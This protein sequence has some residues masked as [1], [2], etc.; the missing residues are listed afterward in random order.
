MST[1][2]L[3]DINLKDIVSK[4]D[5]L[6]TVKEL[7]H[8]SNYDISNLY[9]DRFWD[10][11][12][13]DKW[14]YLD[15]EL[16][17]WMEYR[18]IKIGK[19]KIIKFLNREFEEGEDYKILNNNEFELNAF[20]SAGAVK[21][22]KNEEKRG[23]HN[24]QYIVTS[25]DCFKE[26]CMHIGT[27]KSKEIKKYYITLEKIFKFYLEYQNL[28]QS[29]LLENKDKEIK[30]IK[31]KLVDLSHTVFD[32]KE[33]KKNTYLYIATNKHLSSQN[34][35]KVGVAKNLTMRR[36]GHNNT[37]NANDKFYYTYSV[38]LH[39][40]YVVEYMIKHI[41]KDFK[42][43]DSNEI[44]IIK[45]D[46]LVKIIKNIVQNYEK[47]ITYYN[48]IMKDYIEDTYDTHILPPKNTESDDSE[49]ESESELEKKEEEEIV[50]YNDNPNYSYIRYKNENNKPL[51]K[52]LRCDYTFN[53]TD[54]LQNHYNRKIKCYED[55][56]TERIE[57]IRKQNDNP[58]ILTIDENPEYTYFE[59]YNEEKEE[60]EYYCNRC[61][62]MTP[63]LNILKSHFWKRLVKCY[64]EN[65]LLPNEKKEHIYV[66]KD[67]DSCK[68]YEFLQDDKTMYSCGYCDYQATQRNWQNIMRHLNR[69]KKCYHINYE[70]TVDEGKMK[71]H[72]KCIDTIKTFHCFYCKY[73]TK[74]QQHIIRH[75]KDAKNTCYV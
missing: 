24:K 40:A 47:S 15:N 8:F 1:L 54:S 63:N 71:Y 18:D 12:K 38:E 13:D 4:H 39:N 34:N 56:K 53:R 74:N 29:N 33:L 45:H 22:N 61:D 66:N 41:L 60:I 21:Q 67:G 6:L 65:K 11:I 16:I 73:V 32:F 7:L 64:E 31:S 19:E 36:I 75:F 42:N 68:Y 30:N 25:P 5:T 69:T 62:M 59:K 17:L 23:A 51:Y 43:S 57:A 14:I 26:L 49:P 70:T 50:Y 3:K 2:S 72:I 58:I 46:Y 37:S 20:C 27:S 9:I 52:C 44:Y 35:Y 10:N 55:P 28:Y 48:T